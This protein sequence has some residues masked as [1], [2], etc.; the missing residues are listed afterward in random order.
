[1]NVSIFVLFVLFFTQYVQPQALLHLPAGVPL[2]LI[3]SFTLMGLMI[4][5]KNLMGFLKHKQVK[6]IILL[7]IWMT[8]LTPMAP[9]ISISLIVLKTVW[10]QLIFV[11]AAVVLIN[12]IKKFK[13]LVTFIS[14]LALFFV[15]YSLITQSKF[16]RSAQSVFS[17]F[18]MDPNDYSCYLN[19][20][21]PWIIL[22]FDY[23]NR[24]MKKIYALAIVA[25]I[26]VIMLTYS[27]GG[28]L[29][30]ISVGVILMIYHPQRYKIMALGIVVILTS[31]L[32]LSNEWFNVM[33]TT[34]STETDTASGRLTLWKACIEMFKNHPLGS[35]PYSVPSIAYTFLEKGPGIDPIHS[36]GYVAH[37]FWFTTLAETGIIGS[38]LV[39]YIII[40]NFKDCVSVIK[41]K[42]NDYL[43][44]A[45]V[46]AL[47]SMCGLFVCSSFI[48]TNYYP[49]FF[50][51][52][53]IICAMAAI[54]YYE[55]LK[56]SVIY[57]NRS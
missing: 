45:G 20:M 39:V 5:N 51:L 4:F 46:A 7:M 53:S 1:M 16:Q 49:H 33:G 10:I 17:N 9:V 27:R 19:M 48:T 44:S 43:R 13:M 40:L 8:I 50:Y 32:F 21:L 18:L 57:E 54:P 12:D 31:G 3:A 42:G 55:N 29:G 15:S 23:S 41:T 22:T 25:T 37:S 56:R 6:L 11:I 30:L 35:G 47:A 26:F 34:I 2:F 14:L 38:S 52:T 28:L 24:M 36:Q